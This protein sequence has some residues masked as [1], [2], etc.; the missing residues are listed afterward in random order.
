VRPAAVHTPLALALA[1]CSA[2]SYRADAD[3][4]VY[5]ILD[6]AAAE[7]TGAARPFT[8]DRP[9]HTLRDALLAE[10]R[11]VVIDLAR[12]LDV[13]AENSREFQQEKEAL[14]RA[15]LAL[16]REQ[17]E[18]ALRFAG[19]TSAEAS[20]VDDDEAVGAVAADL[21][22][23]QSS[24]S[25]GRVV[26]SFV[27]SFLKDLLHGGSFNGSSIL[28]LAF[29]QPLL[30]GAGR[31]IA[32]EPLTQA[33]RDVIYAMREFERFRAAFAVRVVADYY[34]ALQD[35]D[36]LESELANLEGTAKN[37]ERTQ[38]LHDSG[39][40]SGVDLDRARQQEFTAR[41]RLNNARAQVDATLDRFKLTLGLPTDA[42]VRP[43]PAELQRLRDMEIADID[44]DEATAVQLA[45]ARRL[46]YRIAVD[47]TEDAARRVLVAE[48]ALHSILDFSAVLEVPTDPGQPLD[49]DWDRVGWAA[50]FDL[51]LA[52]D[53][54]PE[55]NAY[56]TALINLQAALR[57]RE[58]AEDSVKAE[59]RAAQ[60]SLR[61]SLQSYIIQRDL[62]RSSELRLERA[63][64]FLE[65]GRGD[66]LALLDA[67]E[68]LLAAKLDL[69]G[70][71][72]EYALARLELLRDLEGLILEPT[73]L[74]YDPKLPI[75]QGPLLPYGAGGEAAAPVPPAP[76]GGGEP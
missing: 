34:R 10:P 27:T 44:L 52:L 72:V 63:K 29:T 8:I 57:A 53:R 20:G 40:I 58:L 31:R 30:R 3:Q 54:L 11:P 5:G 37:L 66:T 38:A 41:D 28:S 9:E 76:H 73:G 39:R 6:R 55:R 47:A 49:F 1:A 70:A 13:A 32:R 65:A 48:D 62:L 45:L 75:P 42:Q 23:A 71:I 21:S 35:I 14:Y 46:D 64:D 15:A 18:F 33:E 16:T 22:A 61:R 69:T 43:D 2:A 19:G 56:R 7:V 51:D 59:I 74:R 68:D 24:E 26:A 25:G 60:R 17:H 36:N 50:G 4:Q 67:Q 12:A